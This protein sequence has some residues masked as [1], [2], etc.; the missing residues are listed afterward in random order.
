MPKKQ[1]DISFIKN[2]ATQSDEGAGSIFSTMVGD[3]EVTAAPQDQRVQFVAPQYL[4]DSPYQQRTT[5]TNIESLAE[6]I[7][8]LGFRGSLPARHH[9]SMPGFFQLGFGHRRK[10][11]AEMAGVLIPVLVQEITDEQM[12]LLALSEN[13]EREDLT[14]LEEGN[15]FLRLSEEFSMSQEAIAQ[16]VGEE[17]NARI[18]RGY[19]RNRMRAAKLAKRFPDVQSFLEQHP[20]TG[21]LRSIGYLEDEGLGERE[22]KFVL[23][24]LSLDEWTAD[25]VAAAVKILKEGGETAETLLTS[26]R[27]AATTSAVDAQQN[28]HNKDADHREQAETAT[29]TALP[30][31]EDAAFVIKRT[32]QVNDALKRVQRYTKMIGDSA[33]SVDERTA[34]AELVELIQLILTRS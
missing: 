17:R 3:K 1:V 19:V 27:I 11:A 13:Y 7:A 9:P 4:L 23:E 28:G 2:A 15:G 29:D 21:Y 10:R 14:P 5:Y 34:L 31:T 33:P 25:N 18:D 16:F 24:R 6:K 20:G 12:L 22:R 26:N 32:G 30:P 8:T